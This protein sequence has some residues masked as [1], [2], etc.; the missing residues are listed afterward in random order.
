MQWFPDDPRDERARG[1]ARLTG[2]HH[3]RRQPE[4]PT[5]D[6]TAPGVLVDEQLGDQ[7]AGPVRAFGGGDGV[8]DDEAGEGPAVDREGGGE[9]E[10]DGWLGL[11]TLV[12]SRVQHVSDRVDVDL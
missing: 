11:D 10:F 3:D 5:V 9:D 12:A 2:P 4:D 8:G 6:E 7:L 1:R